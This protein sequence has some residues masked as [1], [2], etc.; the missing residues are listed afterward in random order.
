[1]FDVLISAKEEKAKKSKNKEF[2]R[3]RRIVFI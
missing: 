1:L 3:F 2:F